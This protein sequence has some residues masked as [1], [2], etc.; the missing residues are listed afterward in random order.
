ME[1]HLPPSAWAH[2]YNKALVLGLDIGIE[3]IGVWLRKGRAP[4]FAHTFLVSLPEAAPLAKRRAKRAWRHARESRKHREKL[5]KEWIVR[6]GLLSQAALDEMWAKP[7]AFERPFE[8]RH[9]A[10]HSGVPSAHC[11]VICL[12]HIVKHR[13]FDYHLTEEG[14]YPW[15]E[16]LDAK[17]IVQWAKHAPCAPAYR[18]KLLNEIDSDA[19]WRKDAKGEPTEKY[20][21][22]VTAVEARS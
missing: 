3:G 4:L 8:H 1:Y 13:G 10:I 14:A 20:L 7:K 11:L 16:E 15:G 6:H 21:A 19:P 9:R 18:A 12:R 22:V 2:F 17:E 5:L